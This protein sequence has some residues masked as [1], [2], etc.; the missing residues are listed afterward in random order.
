MLDITQ[1]PEELRRRDQ[2]VVR[3]ADKKPVDAK[4]GFAAKSNDP[5]T[6][7]GLNEAA[8]ALIEDP[9][10]FE[11]GGLGFVADDGIEF[12]DLDN[13]IVDGVIR[14]WAAKL[15][16]QLGSYAERSPSGTGIKIWLTGTPELE[17]RKRFKQAHPEGGSVEIY[18][19]RQYSTVTGDAITEER[20]LKPMP[21]DLVES[22]G[23]PAPAEAASPASAGNRSADLQRL[24]GIIAAMPPSI[25]KQDGSGRLIAVGCAILRDGFIGSLGKELFARYATEQSSPAWP[26]KPKTSLS[27]TAKRAATSRRS[28]SRQSRI[29]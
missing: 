19:A 15:V 5:S 22:L 11:G 27:V 18:Y 7:C 29:R 17:S 1:L 3:L 28:N 20:S 13:V 9:D 21:L 23:L 25:E 12:V 26:E 8:V 16:K 24:S 10:R 6:W 4:T 2:W 14:P